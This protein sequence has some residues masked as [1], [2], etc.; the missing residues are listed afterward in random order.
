[1]EGWMIYIPPVAGRTTI[2][3]VV[4][5]GLDSNGVRDMGWQPDSAELPSHY[6]YLDI[7]FLQYKLSNI[8][9]ATV[10]P[11]TSP[12]QPSNI[13]DRTFLHTSF[14]LIVR[15]PHRMSPQFLASA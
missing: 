11:A 14:G 8:S 15:H 3:Y 12:F 6:G 5:T 1:M 7:R 10:S 13:P 4:D 9:M 2:L